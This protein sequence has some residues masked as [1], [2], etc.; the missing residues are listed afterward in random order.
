M[1]IKNEEL[2]ANKII[3]NQ[4]NIESSE[5]SNDPDEEKKEI[6]KS[7]NEMKNRN[8]EFHDYLED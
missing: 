8:K 6:R 3:K 5:D 2:Y 4:K 1:K 7:L